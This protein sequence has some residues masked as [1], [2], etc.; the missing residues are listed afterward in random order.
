MC[1]RWPYSGSTDQCSDYSFKQ[2]MDVNSGHSVRSWM[3]CSF[4]VILVIILLCL[5]G[6]IGVANAQGNIVREMSSCAV[7]YRNTM[8]LYRTYTARPIIR[9]IDLH[10]VVMQFSLR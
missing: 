1:V 7:Q 9:L 2:W 3:D 10:V 8:L 6:F 5:N 4:S